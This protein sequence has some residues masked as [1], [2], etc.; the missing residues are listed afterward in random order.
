M[1]RDSRQTEIASVGAKNNLLVICLLILPS[2]RQTDVSVAVAHSLV[3]GVSVSAIKLP[4][5][6]IWSL[7]HKV[8]VVSVHAA[9]LAVVAASIRTPAM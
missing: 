4:S 6:P 1:R 5:C 2:F 8:A 7:W 3:V 9:A